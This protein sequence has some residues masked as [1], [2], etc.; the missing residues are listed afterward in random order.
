MK[1][2]NKYFMTMNENKVSD[3]IMQYTFNYF[4]IKFLLSTIVTQTRLTV[5]H[6][7]SGP[8]VVQHRDLP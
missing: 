2:G 7:G 1:D 5:D 6:V 3:M 8:Y 4:E